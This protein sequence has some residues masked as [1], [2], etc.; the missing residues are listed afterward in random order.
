M[1]KIF[2]SS[3][4]VLLLCQSGQAIKQAD[5]PTEFIK[6]ETE[7]SL[8]QGLNRGFIN[9]FSGWLEIPRCLAVESSGRIVTMPILGPLTGSSFTAIRALSGVVDILSIGY[10]GRY[11]YSATMPDYV[12]E[13]PWLA[14]DTKN[15]FD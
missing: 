10:F 1:K 7:V 2:C 3:F 12:W 15:R 11:K 9:I 14:A 5:Q 4:I 13:S 6:K 8:G